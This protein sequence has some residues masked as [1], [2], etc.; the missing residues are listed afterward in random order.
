MPISKEKREKLENLDIQHPKLKKILA[1]ALEGW[2][3]S[4]PHQETF[5]CKTS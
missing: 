4:T 3:T 5:G 1:K 2:E